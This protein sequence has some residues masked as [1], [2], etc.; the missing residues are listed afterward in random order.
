M[1]SEEQL[2]VAKKTDR[3]GDKLCEAG[4]IGAVLFS[5]FGGATYLVI[6]TPGFFS[7]VLGYTADNIQTMFRFAAGGTCAGFLSGLHADEIKS[8]IRQ[9]AKGD[10][11][12]AAASLTTAVKA[13][14][15]TMVKM[16]SAGAAT[17]FV[18]PIV[19]TSLTTS[20][21]FNAI[22]ETVYISFAIPF[23]GAAARAGLKGV[24]VL[25][26]HINRPPKPI[27]R[28]QSPNGPR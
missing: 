16:A 14:P 18:A 24:S 26:R 5:L 1:S 28:G 25:V 8:I 22:V 20:S 11:A 13:K 12:N 23:V 21:S 2:D 15:V 7:Y 27:S 19:I 17:G 3:L 6:L 10:F 4:L 9:A